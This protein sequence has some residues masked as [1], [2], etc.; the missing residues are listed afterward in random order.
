MRAAG[1]LIMDVATRHRLPA[2]GAL[3]VDR[4]PF[5]QDV[6]AAIRAHPLITVTE[7]EITAA[8]VAGVTVV[9][10]RFLDMV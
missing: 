8:V 5:A 7:E 6:T 10:Q 1:S 2:G 3:A 4:D 9:P